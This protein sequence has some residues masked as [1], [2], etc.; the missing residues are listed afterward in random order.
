MENS[1]HPLF[2]YQEILRNSG[3][4]LFSYNRQTQP[5]ERDPRVEEETGD[6]RVERI[7]RVRLME[8]LL[9]R[10]ED[11]VSTMPKGIWRVEEKWRSAVGCAPERALRQANRSGGDP[12]TV[13][14]MAAPCSQCLPRRSAKLRRLET[15]PAASRNLDPKRETVSNQASGLAPIR[16]RIGARSVPMAPRLPVRINRPDLSTRSKY[17]AGVICRIPRLPDSV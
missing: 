8:L 13:R 17:S 10:V 7:R 1:G 11:I 2:S 16:S 4:P 14:A 6:N 3:H 5:H 9:V 12:K 15:S